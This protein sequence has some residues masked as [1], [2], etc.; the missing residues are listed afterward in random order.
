VKTL[1]ALAVLAL[2][3]AASAPPEDPTALLLRMEAAYAAV[4]DYTARF[5]RQERIGSD[6]RPREEALLKFQRPGRIYLRWLDGPRRG[7]QLLFVPGRDGARVL[8]HEPGLLSGRFT[9]LMAPDS[10][11][12]LR[13]SRHPVTD[14]GF[15]PL[16]DLILGSVRR[17]LE[18]REIEIIDHGTVPDSGGRERRLTLVLRRDP[19]RGY[20]CH[21]A[22]VTIDRRLG[23]PVGV[24]V[25]DWADRTVAVYEY[26]DVRLN[27]GLGPAD[28]DPA[29]P[30]YA[31]PRWRISL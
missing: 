29:S 5:I 27:P 20:Y 22:V 18:R 25:F 7:R 23:L 1:S 16:I 26:R 24:T 10:P 14:V 4:G 9:V 11:R 2:G 3:A 21:R 28:F 30:E 12:I 15:G 8:V 13:E 31:F 19:A 17:G 6:L